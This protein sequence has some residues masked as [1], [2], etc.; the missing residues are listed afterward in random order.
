VRIKA[1]DSEG[2]ENVARYINR[3]PLSVEKVEYIPGKQSAIY[4][5]KKIVKGVN[6][7]FEIFDP[8]V[9]LAKLTSHVPKNVI[10]VI[11]TMD[12]IRKILKHLKLWEEPIPRAP[13]E[14][15]QPPDIEYVPFLD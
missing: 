1:D 10:S 4:R 11:D 12:V 9:F 8:L 3:A 6:R 13:P 5:A 14:P 15:E 2:R 7:N